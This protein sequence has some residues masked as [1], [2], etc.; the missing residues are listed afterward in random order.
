M[1]YIFLMKLLFKNEIIDYDF[2]NSRK[3]QTILF[4]HGWGGN[5]F[6]FSQTINLLKNQFNILSI[7][8]P[9]TES[10]TSVWNMFDYT[11]LIENILS[12]YNIQNPII[13]CHSFGCRV[14][15]LLNKKI[16]ISKL[17]V[18]GGAGLRK[19]NIFLKIIKNNNKIILKNEKFN[20]LFKKIASKDYLSLSSFNKKTFQKIVNLNLKF[21]IKFNCPILLFWGTKDKDT[22][23]WI[24]KTLKRKNNTKLITTKSDHFAY[25]KESSKFNHAVINFLK[26]T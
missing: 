9:T 23:P 19:E 8:M 10:T 25:L 11:Q 7:T 6:S 26:N 4:L 20:Y 15:M 17:I 1:A 24:A 21:A 22:K 2:F 13:I 14:A 16:K 18:T 3:E 5:K 12:I